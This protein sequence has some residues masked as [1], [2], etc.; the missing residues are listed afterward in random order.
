[1]AS[2]LYTDHTRMYDGTASASNKTGE[3]DTGL[4]TADV[5]VYE[6]ELGTDVHVFA[7]LLGDK[8]KNKRQDLLKSSSRR[9]EVYAVAG[10]VEVT[11]S[12]QESSRRATSALALAGRSLQLPCIG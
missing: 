4:E 7:A 6:A 3:A 10:R 12:L 11:D 9:R 1:M 5:V 8:N 2:S